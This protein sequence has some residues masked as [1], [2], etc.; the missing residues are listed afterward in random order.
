VDGSA[1]P[2]TCANLLQISGNS[3]GLADKTDGSKD[4]EKTMP[5]CSHIVWH[6]DWNDFLMDYDWI[7]MISSSAKVS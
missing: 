3:R 2:G 4:F 5:G 6:Y 1:D 7:T